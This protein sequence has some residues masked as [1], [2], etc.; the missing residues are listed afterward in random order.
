M[1]RHRR[2]GRCKWC[3]GRYWVRRF[4]GLRLCAT[5]RDLFLSL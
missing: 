2:S 4:M 1:P 3:K 5:C